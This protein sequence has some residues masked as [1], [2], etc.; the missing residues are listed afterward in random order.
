MYKNDTENLIYKNI[1]YSGSVIL[2]MDFQPQ[3]PTETLPGDP[4]A[5]VV[6]A[7]DA[8]TGIPLKIKAW[9]DRM[10]LIIGKELYGKEQDVGYITPDEARIQQTELLIEE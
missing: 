5:I 7:Q 8:E 10:L 1:G 9:M 6:E 3:H 4:P 2:F